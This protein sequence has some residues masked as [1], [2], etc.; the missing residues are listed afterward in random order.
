[1]ADFTNNVRS[2]Y[3]RHVYLQWKQQCASRTVQNIV[4][5]LQ[6][7]FGETFSCVPEIWTYLSPKMESDLDFEK[8]HTS[9][10]G[11]FKNE[12]FNQLAKLNQSKY[13]ENLRRA[14]AMFVLITAGPAVII[15]SF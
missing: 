8:W 5:H 9:I 15:S 6:T 12:R 10:F 13:Y 4:L 2:R 11:N 7:E 14:A 1:M 3:G